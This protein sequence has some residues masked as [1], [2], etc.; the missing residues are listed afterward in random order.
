M[1]REAVT[2]QIAA[3]AQNI[4][5][6]F[7]NGHGDAF[8]S[9]PAIR[10]IALTVPERVTLLTNRRAGFLWSALP[11]KSIVTTEYP[12]DG[13]GRRV[14]GI[15]DVCKQI[16][17]VDLFISIV[18][19]YSRDFPVLLQ[20]LEA[21]V[22]VGIGEG[23][24]VPVR[25]RLGQHAAE[26]AFA[27]IRAVTNNLALAVFDEPVSYA[28]E[29]RMAVADYLFDLGVARFITL[30]CDTVIEKRWPVESWIRLIDAIVNIWPDF[31]VI[32]IGM[33]DIGLA[34]SL[35]HP[36]VCSCFG[37]SF[38]W[39]CGLLALASALVCIDSAFL[40]VAD[41]ARVPLVAIFQCTSAQEFGPRNSHSV[42][43]VRST[44]GIAPSAD[45]VVQALRVLLLV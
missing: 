35:N 3:K 38:E 39:T 14:V 11:L 10:A 26:L 8:I 34:E 31:H 6:L 36:R 33:E 25:R 15:E 12:R 32:V 4:V 19:W 44:S 18:P 45:E 16:G 27:P 43:L 37:E 9:L 24:Q 20:R 42:T 17:T 2:A 41:N 13:A 28:S 21:A 29:I 7:A 40:H 30:H 23:W 5:V 22:T 1:L